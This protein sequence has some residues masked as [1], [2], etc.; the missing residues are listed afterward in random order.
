LRKA[1]LVSP[2]GKQSFIKELVYRG[3]DL[4]ASIGCEVKQRGEVIEVY[5]FAS[6]V[7]LFGTSMPRKT[8]RQGTEFLNDKLGDILPDLRP[9]LNVFNHDLCDAAMAAH[10]ALLYHQN[11]VES[12]GNGEEGVII[13]PD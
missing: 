8:T 12:L 6:K 4:K 3:I 9:Y 5:P 10:T 13:V 7:R 11:R 1:V 2:T